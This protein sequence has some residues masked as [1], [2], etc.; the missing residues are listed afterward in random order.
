MNQ[1]SFYSPLA[2]PPP[3]T[4][5]KPHPPGTSVFP[6][7]PG[8]DSPQLEPT[9]SLGGVIPFPLS[10]P[11]HLFQFCITGAPPGSPPT[12]QASS[13]LPLPHPILPGPGQP[14][15][16]PPWM[17]YPDL[18]PPS[19]ALQAPHSSI[20]HLPGCRHHK[21]PCLCSTPLI[22]ELWRQR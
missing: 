3:W 20:P 6:I 1:G 17:D 8:L 12:S 9:A 5:R 21:T 15:T 10:Y 18:G 7:D 11:W 22:P 4:V 2:Q 16:S 19:Q 13:L 14:S